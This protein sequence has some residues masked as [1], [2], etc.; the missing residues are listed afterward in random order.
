MIIMIRT[1]IWSLSYLWSSA[2]VQSATRKKSEVPQLHVVQT[3][4]CDLFLEGGKR[5]TG[6]QVRSPK[7]WGCFTVLNKFHKF[8]KWQLFASAEFPKTVGNK[9]RQISALKCF[10]VSLDVVDEKEKLKLASASSLNDRGEDGEG[11]GK[12]EGR[13]GRI[14]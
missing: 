9:R 1:R 4:R 2:L 7:G 6:A 5:F 11:G 10:P 12:R 3:N 13:G 14:A 8:G